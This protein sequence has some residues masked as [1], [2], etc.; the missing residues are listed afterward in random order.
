MPMLSAVV[1]LRSNTLA[2]FG[3]KAAA[4]LGAGF[5]K[6]LAESEATRVECAKARKALPRHKDEPGC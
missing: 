6:A 1:V 2:L 3:R 4:P 5:K